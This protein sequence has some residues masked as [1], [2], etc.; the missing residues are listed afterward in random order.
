MM[1]VRPVGRNA[2]DPTGAASTMHVVHVIP[3]LGR[4]GAETVL[5]GVLA[6]MR[7]DAA[8]RH[9]VVSLTP[10]SEFDF[11]GIGVTAIEMD[12]HR[13]VPLPGDAIRLRARIASLRPD[14]VQ[15]W[16]YHGN[17]AA[18]ACSPRG[19]PVLFGIHH[20]LDDLSAEKRLTRLVIRVG[21]LAARRR[22][23]AVAYCSD[24]GRSQ[25]EAIGYPPDRSEY[26]P[27]GFDLDRF[28]P[29]VDEAERATIRARLGLPERAMVIGSVARLHPVK[30]HIGLLESFAGLAVE[31]PDAFLVMA[32]RGVVDS[33]GSLLRTIE[34]LGID[35]R[36]R[37]L[38]PRDDVPVLLR[39]FDVF[40]SASLAEA[41]P[42]SI[43][44]AL[45]SGVPCVATD[46]GDC[47]ALVGDSC[48]VAK[49]ADTPAFTA[50]LS[51]TLGMGSPRLREVGLRARDRMAARHGIRASASAYSAL[52]RRVRTPR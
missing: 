25:H 15:G 1:G 9:T 22:A 12:A 37:L 11:S 45:A 16:M 24:R 44:E 17:L 48:A 35:R 5:Y 29:A 49:R 41:F 2:A 19:V 33:E 39:A 36:V 38:G 51:R 27:N 7:D 30:N 26:L 4:G 34:R 46:V 23:A 18:A 20:A 6:A 32:G 52:Y 42:V 40:A 8:I 50:A 43:G 21:A 31:H 10:G 13:G 14:V 28:R 3:G 47:A